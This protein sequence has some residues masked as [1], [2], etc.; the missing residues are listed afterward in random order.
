M[1]DLT[2]FL[3]ILIGARL[4]A[5]MG[6]DWL[7]MGAAKAATGEVPAPFRSFLNKET[8]QKS[9]RYTL[10]KLRFGMVETIFDTAVLVLILFS[11]FLP[12]LWTGLLDLVG[13]GIWG[14]AI[15]LFTASV[16]FGLPGIPFELI[17]QFKIEEKYGFN[18]ST[19]GLWTMD[20]IKGLVLGAILGIPLLALLL[21][22]VGLSTY[23]WIFGFIIV[24]G[25]QLLMI[26]VYPMFIMPL[27]NKFEP[28][29]EGTLR[30]RLMALGTR[31]GFCAKTILVMDGSRRSAHSNAFFTG[32]GNF[33]RI[34]LYDTLVEQMGERELE[35]VLAHE[36]G[37][38]RLG[39][40]PRMLLLSAISLA[41]AFAALGWISHQAWFLES[42]GFAAETGMGAVFLLFGLLAGLV[43]FWMTPLGNSLSRK[44]EFEADAFS[45]TA[46]ESD[47]QPLISALRGLSEK[48]L[49]NLTPH[50]WY[51]RF[52]Y[53]HPTLLERERSL[54]AF[55]KQ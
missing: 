20:K 44:H 34:V 9:V 7:N 36:I 47:A 45:A 30:E 42:F 41:V 43:S 52:Y 5:Q 40:I 46:M 13:S 50:P 31:T 23:W 25:F 12:W 33:R 19:L 4:A 10:E 11:G 54:A 14:Q 28:L 39:H 22:L 1:N 21:W 3:A 53:S 48:N 51:S 27:F 37:H 26:V 24:F 8:Y 18:K 35:A 55:P 32:F 15:A 2:L 16:L 49:S 29:P 6:L 17:F 38:Y